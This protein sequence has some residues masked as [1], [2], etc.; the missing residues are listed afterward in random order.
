[1][2]LLASAYDKSKYLRAEDLKRDTKF[3]IKAVTEEMFDKDGKAEKKL[4]C[5]FTNDDRGLVLNKTN[6]R[7]IRGAYGDV[8]AGLIGKI[9]IVF[10]M[11]TDVRGASNAKAKRELAWHPAY[12]SWRQGFAA[13]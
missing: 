13:A 10:P 3:R 8:P 2:E 11:M 1:M 7:T 6:N 12:P 4:V 9:I 5:W